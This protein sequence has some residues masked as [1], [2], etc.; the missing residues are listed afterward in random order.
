MTTKEEGH[1]SAGWP[2]ADP[3]A[4]SDPDS[5]ATNDDTAAAGHNGEH[6]DFSDFVYAMAA[7]DLDMYR[8]S[9]TETQREADK[10][11]A[12]RGD[13]PWPG[14][15]PARPPRPPAT[16]TPATGDGARW[17]PWASATVEAKCA[18]IA[19]T[20]EGSRNHTLNA[21]GLRAYRAALRGGL[22]PATVTEAL[23]AAGR[24]S[25]LGDTEVRKTLESAWRKAVAEGPAD[26]PPEREGW[27]AAASTIDPPASPNGDGS[28]PDSSDPDGLEGA[29]EYQMRKM[30]V[31]R[32]A[33]R[34]LDDEDRPPVVVPPAKGLTALL[35]EPD[36][37]VSYLIEDVAPVGGRVILSAQYKAGKTTIVGNLIRSLADGDPFLGRFAV[38]ARARVALIDTEMSEN[39]LR[40]W[41][42]DQG[43][44]NT[45]AVVDV[46]ALR[47]KVSSL[48]L[49]DDRCRGRWATRLRDQG[50]EHLIL[51][52]LRPVLDAL[53]LEE[54]HDAGRF[55]VAFD[56]LLDE[57]G[58]EGAT[59]I[60]HMGH[61]N[62][63]SRG[64]S[65]LQDWPDAIWRLV[66]ETEE[67]D[68]ARFFSAYGRDVDLPEGRLGYDPATRRVTYAPGS[69]ADTKTEA[70]LTAVIP[71][72]AAAK[73]DGLSTNAIL[74]QA[75]GDHPHRAVRGALARGI[76]LGLI[77]VSDGPHGAKLH[78][79]ASP[80]A[81]C[82]LPLTAGQLGQHQSC[83][84]PGEGPA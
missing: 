21:Q 59:L 42:A 11:R 66:R 10:I 43:I 54:N 41:L 73:D 30:R 13:P 68:S 18:T 46:A 71:L 57:A 12:D 60:Q 38:T 23:T 62:E 47:G 34:R 81:A 2:P 36:T 16:M 17:G 3:S 19:T 79:I 39:T 77:S 75:T 40:R 63:R 24:A 44:G 69:R 55:L 65:R 4:E 20:P 64:D 28:T 74:E 45:A 48:N 27:D 70:A 50:C 25:G 5:T 6:F 8:G 76:K 35:A 14:A 51:D 29:I 31:S 32:E 58:I 83:L 15:E 52:C 7:N 67:P 56:A 26:P 61:A 49:L 1:P 33:S 72:L 80:C 9:N 82:G 78:H 37:P 53:G 84:P 22:D